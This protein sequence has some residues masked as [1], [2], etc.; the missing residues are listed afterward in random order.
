MQTR[1][2][3]QLPKT[4]QHRQQLDHQMQRIV[5][6]MTSQVAQRRQALAAL[7]SQLELLNPQRTLERGYSMM[8]DNKGRIIRA[9]KDLRPRETVT[10][11]LAEG[12]AEVGIASVQPSLE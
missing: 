3:A 5:T 7:S 11:R 10:V 1:L 9:P 4:R 12:S 8:I 6:R 2:I